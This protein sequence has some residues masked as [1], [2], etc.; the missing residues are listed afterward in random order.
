MRSS[1]MRVG[2]KPNDWRPYKRKER[3][4]LDAEDT[5]RHTQRTDSQVEMKAETGMVSDLPVP[6]VTGANSVK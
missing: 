5:R 2:P 1:R 3:E 4:V 6:T